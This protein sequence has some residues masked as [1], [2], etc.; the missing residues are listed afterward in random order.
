MTDANLYQPA[1]ITVTRGTTLTWMNVGNVPHTVTDDP[2]KA[3][4][5]SDAMLPEGA[6][7]WDSG[8]IAGNSS[9]THTFDTAGEYTY[10]C[11]PHESLG[12]VGRVIVT[13]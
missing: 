2:S 4:N 3:A 10:F 6:Q 7:P 8:Y 9:F 5:R 12:M 11:I 13:S 1:T